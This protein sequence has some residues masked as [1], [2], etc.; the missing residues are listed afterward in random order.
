MNRYPERES[1][2]TL[3]CGHELW[4]YDRPEDPSPDLPFPGR[5]IYCE[6]CSDD[7]TI[8]PKTQTLKDLVL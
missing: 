8:V 6:D 5:V 4:W 2:M 3:D 1:N 7:S